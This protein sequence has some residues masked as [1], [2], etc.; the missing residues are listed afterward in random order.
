MKIAIIAP[1]PVPF[2][3]GG[4]EFLY[5]GM[6]NAINNFSHHQCELIKLPVKENSFWGIIDSYYKFYTLDLT[7][8]DMII[9]TKYPSW[10]VQHPNHILYMVHPLRGLYDTYHFFGKPEKIPEYPIISDIENIIAIL[11]QKKPSK[12]T[13][14]RFFTSIQMMKKNVKD[15]PREL[16]EFPGPFIFEIVHFLDGYA[17][18]QDKIKKYFTMSE[19]V[20]KRRDYFPAEVPVQVV[21][22]PPFSDSFRC[23]GYHY[24]FTASRLD[25]AKRIDLI[26]DAMKYVPYQ[27]ALKI[28]GT[29]P[30][31]KKLRKKAV[32]D[33]R[34]EFLNFVSNDA[35][36]EYYAD[37]LAVIFTPYDEDY[38]FITVEAMKSGKPVITTTDSG[39]PLEFVNNET[40]YVVPPDPEKI[41]E[42]INFFI[43]N[44]ETAIRMGIAAREKI[45]GLNWENFTHRLLNEQNSGSA[46]KKILVLSTYSSFPPRG[47]GQQRLYN[48]YSRLAKKSDVTICSIIESHK[49]YENFVLDNGLR[50]ICIPQSPEHARLQSNEEKKLRKNIYD[51]SM[52]E[53]L[54]KSPR[55][56]DE[57]KKLMDTADH[58]ILFHPY[59]F[60]VTKYMKDSSSY[61]LESVD[62]EYIQK[63]SYINDEYWL[64]KIY[65]NEQQC[66][67]NSRMI[68]TTSDDDKRTLSELYAINPGKIQVVPN[69]VNTRQIQYI[70]YDDHCRQKSLCRIKNLRTLLFVGSW[71]PPNLEALRF[72][73]MELLPN[74]ENT[75]LLLIGSIRDYY[76]SEIGKLPENILAFGVVDELE[77]YEIYKLAD[78]AV[79]PMFSG[80][81][82]NIKMLDYFSAGIPVVTTRTGA[83]GLA[84]EDEKEAII[85]D[86]EQML[87]SILKLMGDRAFQDKLRENARALVESAYSWDIIAKTIENHI[88]T[89]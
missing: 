16:F 53:F 40:G 24:L 33:K 45:Q 37:A 60:P 74:L 32:N 68:F 65:S 29:G 73:V 21:H 35:L 8:F 39:G 25:N 43:E 56:I 57:A 72:I 36:Q 19:N 26:I 71:H 82:T 22:P 13:V 66:C 18:A 15:F 61:L 87:P 12:D 79:N 55:F 80:S 58:V 34:I 38:G 69:G 4:A 42:K 23:T 81:G 84:I 54:E 62:I 85:C 1:S 52:I 28:A 30:E 11:R 46:R 27:I 76:L 75:K 9:S 48:I 83:R 70:T 88:E 78:I 51:C 5:S 59:L 67:E 2:T 47:G 3:L 86:P 41:A 64:K 44:K 6:Q 77:K 14:D 10:M 20:K 89:I 63:K 7:S 50:Q 17:L 49:N 31:E